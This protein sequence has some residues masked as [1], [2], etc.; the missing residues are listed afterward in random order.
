M[1]QWVITSSLL[2]LLIVLLRYALKG[3]ISLKLQYALWVLVLIR[4][5]VPVSFGS[6]CISVMNA[7]DRYKEYQVSY[8]TRTSSQES[9]TTVSSGDYYEKVTSENEASGVS[10]SLTGESLYDQVIKEEHESKK[11]TS[12]NNIS[13][14]SRLYL[15]WLIGAVVVG[16]WLMIANLSFAL[17]L[18]RTRKTIDISSFPL[19]VYC[20]DILDTSCLFGLFKPAIYIS[21]EDLDKELVLNYVLEHEMTH[22][23]HLD[24]I[25]SF[26]RCLCIAVHWY[27]PLVWLAASLSKQD[28]ELACDEATIRKIGED[29]RSSYGR[30]LIELTCSGKGKGNLVIAATTMSGSKKRIKERIA[31]IAQRPR[32]AFYTLIL[33]I[34]IVAAAIGCIFT[35]PRKSTA[36]NT[37]IPTEGTDSIDVN[38]TKIF[39]DTIKNAVY[40]ID[41]RNKQGNEEHTDYE[42][43]SKMR[44]WVQGFTYGKKCTDSSLAL[45]NDYYITVTMQMEQA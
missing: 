15:L 17:R 45:N 40:A 23:R 37:K 22:F 44:K 42:Y 28:A 35:G 27:N 21:K 24:H 3:K 1:T 10:E 30:T 26:L 29:S 25:W 31:M 14:S 20:T 8:K 12:K 43:L 5:L 36:A 16:L 32:M 9:N 19:K 4:L 33:V 13:I 11:S 39:P 38:N 18:K 41:I 2:I 34:F 7:V 6:S